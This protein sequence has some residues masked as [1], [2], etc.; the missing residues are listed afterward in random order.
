MLEQIK[1]IKRFGAF[2]DF[3]WKK[4][5]VAK[6]G[7]VLKCQPI[8]F[9]YGRNYSGKTTLSK[10]VQS[11]ER[12][13]LPDHYDGA[14]FELEFEGGITL[15]QAQVDQAPTPIRV[16]NRDFVSD[17]LAFLRDT[18]ED[19]RIT[20][21]AI[22]GSGAPKLEK[23]IEKLKEELGENTKENCTGMCKKYRDTKAIVDAK[24]KA[25]TAI[26]KSISKLKNTIANDSI[27]GIKNNKVYGYAKYNV[28]ALDKDIESVRQPG[29]ADISD[30]DVI[31]LQNII[32][33]LP[34]PTV[35][36][37]AAFYADYSSL[38]DRVKEAATRK[39][40]VGQKIEDLFNDL[41][42]QEWV[43]KGCEIH[44]QDHS[45]C[46]FC[47]QDIPG[48]RWTALLE[49]F[50]DDAEKLHT[51]IQS[52]LKELDA[53]R[54]QLKA[55]DPFKGLDFY[56]SFQDKVSLL[57]ENM[58]REIENHLFSIDQLASILA[59]REMEIA[60][61][62]A[63]DF[64]PDLTPNYERIFSALSTLI[65]QNNAYTSALE[66]EKSKAI[67]RLRLHRVATDIVKG[68][69]K[70]LE[71]TLTE[72]AKDLRD[73]ND[74]LS[75]II[76]HGKE[77][78]SKLNDLISQRSD[79]S[80]A[81]DCI[82]KYLSWL[83][84]GNTLHLQT[85]VIEDGENKSKVFKIFRGEKEAY[86]LSEGE[87]NLIAFCYFMASL[88]KPE[89][90]TNKPI[91][92]IDD[93]ISSLDSN[94]IYF[95]YSL[96]RGIIIAEE[97][98]SQL[99]ISTHNLE[100]LRLLH[101]LK[102]YNKVTK[103]QLDHLWLMTCRKL[104]ASTIIPMP[105]YLKNYAT[106]FSHLFLRICL[107]ASANETDDNYLQAFYEFGNSAR[108]FL[109]LYLYYRFPNDQKNEGMEHLRQIK[110]VFGDKVKAFISERVL[111]EMS[112]LAG[113]LE[114]GMTMPEPAEM[115]DVARCILESVKQHD[116]TQYKQLLKGTKIKDPLAS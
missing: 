7:Q 110:I 72:K 57:R 104:D 84:D 111:N 94:H 79:E 49:H 86:N 31:K 93:P 80:A 109:E 17:N 39:I 101:R 92:W 29:F 70:G 95:I 112:H 114:R 3:E 66:N 34:K 30:D 23:D 89:L 24:S 106:E 20:S 87:G 11:F 98:F 5:V 47:G 65:S 16:F 116:I 52:L 97:L 100:F 42:K 6:D 60:T 41:D 71:D 74:D 18:R 15:N 54:Q 85:I 14:D 90:K 28:P 26:D 4:S 59:K 2:K 68:D 64:P 105:L 107:A 62:Y 46:A 69:L 88:S 27:L 36:L 48:K 19:G 32:F 25:V 91:I 37:P 73:A 61:P 103:K 21:F 78:R 76:E 55:L 13:K 102:G 8:N 113:G 50:S 38:L 44:A 53:K 9:I 108:R 58:R 67:E 82:N 99:F 45:V 75:K 33:E 51:N 35:T 63:S 83:G 96:I 77:L 40:I 1:T 43:R 56:T 10:L 22:L 81:A 115:K 12:K